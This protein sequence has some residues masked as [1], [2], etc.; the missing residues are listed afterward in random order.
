M[1]QS[2][3]QALLYAAFTLCQNA[4]QTKILHLTSTFNADF[5][6]KLQKTNEPQPNHP[7]Y[8]LVVDYVPHPDRN[9]CDT[10][11]NPK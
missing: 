1:K 3:I 10:N 8:V 7:Q 4:I 6:A 9:A 11:A 5:G 2:G